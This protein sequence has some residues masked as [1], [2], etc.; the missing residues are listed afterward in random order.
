PV[1]GHHG[2]VEHAARAGAVAAPAGP[3]PLLPALR[4]LADPAIA[5][6]GRAA[7]PGLVVLLLAGLRLAALA[8]GRLGSDRGRDVLERLLLGADAEEDLG[9]AADRHHGRADV[10]R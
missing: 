5:L 8:L 7:R 3:L 1:P 9:D 4:P 10:E 6:G 2:R